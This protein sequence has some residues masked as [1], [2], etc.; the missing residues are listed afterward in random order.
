MLPTL[1]RTAAAGGPTYFSYENMLVM[2][3]GHGEEGPYIAAYRIR[4]ATKAGRADVIIDVH[5]AYMK[6]NLAKELSSL[7]FYSLVAAKARGQK[8]ARSA[9]RPW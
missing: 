6:P 2:D 5:S 7:P 4:R 3:N 1:F 8:V 9:P